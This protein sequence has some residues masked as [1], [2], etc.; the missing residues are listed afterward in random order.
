MR[1]YFVRFL[2]IYC[3]IVSS[4]VRFLSAQRILVPSAKR[5]KECVSD[6]TTVIINIIMCNRKRSCPSIHA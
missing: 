5:Q 4:T 6:G 3:F 1:Y 2:C